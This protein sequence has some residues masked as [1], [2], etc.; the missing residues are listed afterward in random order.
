[1]SVVIPEKILENPSESG[2]ATDVADE[3]V[4]SLIAK[5]KKLIRKVDFRLLPWICLLCSLLFIDRY[6]YCIPSRLIEDI[7]LVWPGSQV[8]VKHSTWS[9]I[10]PITLRYL[11]SFLG[12]I[13]HLALYVLIIA[14]SYLA[15][16]PIS[17]SVESDLRTC[18]HSQ[19]SVGAS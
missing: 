12:N 5:D 17:L 18:L 16:Y 3:D 9:T 2:L 15:F 4:D 13:H 1:M 8:W 10:I 11:C 7:T 6:I 19:S 14:T